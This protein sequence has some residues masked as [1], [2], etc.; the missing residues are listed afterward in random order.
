M[1]M[2]ANLFW[3]I[4]EIR[5]NRKYSNAVKQEIFSTSFW[6]DYVAAI[7]TAVVDLLYKIPKYN[8]IRTL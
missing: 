6:P 1:A 7:A 4:T 3:Q 5:R 2:K 8:S